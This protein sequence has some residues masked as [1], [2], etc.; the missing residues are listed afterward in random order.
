M[1]YS[2]ISG[3]DR[4]RANPETFRLPAD[5]EKA[6]ITPGQFV[7]IIFSEEGCNPERMWVEVT[8]KDGDLITGVLSN[9]PYVLSSVKYGD[10]VEFGPEHVIQILDAE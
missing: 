1:T 6:A 7:K 4:A 2:L 3:L 9:V 5:D 10:E 8:A